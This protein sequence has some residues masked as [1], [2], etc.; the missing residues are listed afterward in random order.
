MRK[1]TVE[2]GRGTDGASGRGTVGLS[3][4]IAINLSFPRLHS[5]DKRTLELE[6]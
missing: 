3:F 5:S 4:E 6:T 1:G 2:Q